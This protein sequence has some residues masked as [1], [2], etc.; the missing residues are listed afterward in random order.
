MDNSTGQNCQEFNK[1]ILQNHMIEHCSWRKKQKHNSY[2]IQVD[3][4]GLIYTEDKP[5]GRLFKMCDPFRVILSAKR[6]QLSSAIL[7]LYSA[8]RL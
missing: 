5:L 8:Q 1:G 4:R 3:Q 6:F 7:L 2:Y